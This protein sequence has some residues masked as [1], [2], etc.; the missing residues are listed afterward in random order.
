[1]HWPVYAIVEHGVRSAEG[2]EHRV[3]AIVL[4]DPGMLGSRRTPEPRNREERSA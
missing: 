1:V 2:I 3:D 4:P